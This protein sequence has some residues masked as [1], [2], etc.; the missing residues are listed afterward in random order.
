MIMN[1]RLR[2]IA[3]NIC[4]GGAALLWLSG[5]THTLRCDTPLRP[6]NTQGSESASPEA[7]R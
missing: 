3:L 6:I 1:I 2:K 7:T 4:V 5:C